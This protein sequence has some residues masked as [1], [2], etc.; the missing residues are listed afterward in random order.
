MAG[1]LAMEVM[2][3]Y[4]ITQMDYG[5]NLANYDSGRVIVFKLLTSAVSL[6]F[7]AISF[8]VLYYVPRFF[9][10]NRFFTTILY[11][12]LPLFLFSNVIY[13]RYFEMPMSLGVLH[14]I[15][16]LP[17]S[18]AML[19]LSLVPR[20]FFTLFV[21]PSFFLSDSNTLRKRACRG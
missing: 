13:H 21:P 4:T 17:S 8:A 5:L 9:P 19:W 11:G 6:F 20:I 16:N 3:F 2:F 7:A 1:V 15:G 14:S 18:V 12:G 10:G